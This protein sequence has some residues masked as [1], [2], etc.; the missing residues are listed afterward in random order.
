MMMMVT[1]FLCVFVSCL[2][3][4]LGYITG[5]VDT[6][7]KFL[8]SHGSDSFTVNNEK[9]TSGKSKKTVSIDESKVVVDVDVNFSKTEELELGEKS[10]TADDITSAKNKL[11]QLKKGK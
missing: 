7:F 8:G 2:F 11:S 9:R 10:V 4:V 6:I 1:L 3:F 5:R